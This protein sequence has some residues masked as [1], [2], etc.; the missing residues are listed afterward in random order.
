[1]TY[2][3]FIY[4]VRDPENFERRYAKEWNCIYEVYGVQ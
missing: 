4:D 3:Y 1:M 2:E